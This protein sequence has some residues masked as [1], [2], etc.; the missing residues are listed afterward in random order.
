MPGRFRFD[1][2]ASVAPDGALQRQADALLAMMGLVDRDGAP[3]AELSYGEKRRLEI[4]IALATDPDVLL[5]DEPLAGLSPQE[6][7]QVVGVI[8]TASAGRTTLVVEHDMDA[9]FGLAD[10]IAVLHTGRNLAVGPPAEIRANPIVHSA[11]LGGK[12]GD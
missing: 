12:D 5:L 6:R 8:R 3:A 7:V 10:R 1:V 2:L 11:Y 9:L 4:G